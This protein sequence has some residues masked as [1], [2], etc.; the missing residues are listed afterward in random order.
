MDLQLF[1]LETSGLD[2]RGSTVTSGVPFPEGTVQDPGRLTLWDERE[3]PIPV[4]CTVLNR[5]PDGSI[6]WVLLDFR[7]DVDADQERDL[8]LTDTYPV[9]AL[10][11]VSCV[12]SRNRGDR[13]VLDTSALRFNIPKNL[14]APLEEVSLGR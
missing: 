2:R 14:S 7:V 3:D 6:R 12:R 1:V 4:Q 11:D 9:P 8:M 13:L 10:A 5:W